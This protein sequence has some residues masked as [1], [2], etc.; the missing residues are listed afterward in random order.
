MPLGLIIWTGI[1]F[2][3][4]TINPSDKDLGRRV[5]HRL[6]AAIIVFFIPIFVRLVLK[7]VDIGGGKTADGSSLSN[8]WESI[9]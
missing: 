3:K 2:F 1:D 8:C 5:L 9:K 6:I 7:L 4:G